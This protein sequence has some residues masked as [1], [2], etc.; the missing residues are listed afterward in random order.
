[1]PDAFTPH[2]LNDA[3]HQFH[4]LKTLA[5]QAMAQISD[6]DLFTVLDEEANSI[7]VLLKHMAGSMRARWTAFPSVADETPDRHRDS[8]FVIEEGDTKGVLLEQWE[9]GWQALFDA[10]RRLTTEDMAATVSIRGKSLSVIEAINRQLTHYAYHVG[11]I[12]FLAKHF[13]SGAWQ[14]LSIP[15]GK[16][17][18]FTTA[19]PI[20]AHLQ[21]P[22]R[23][24]KGSLRYMRASRTSDD[25]S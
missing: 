17:E 1:M 5:E 13:R 21:P 8:E 25:R 22:W 7:A 16:S 11:Q 20:A 12:V 9:V 18:E 3:V 15:R 19:G 24:G 6:E 10:L 14:L 2:Y 23:L 4:T